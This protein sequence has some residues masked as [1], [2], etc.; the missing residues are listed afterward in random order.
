MRH[1]YLPKNRWQFT[2]QGHSPHLGVT[3][4]QFDSVFFCAKHI[5]PVVGLPIKQWVMVGE[6]LGF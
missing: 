2:L 4:P 3:R 5:A 6:G 1:Q